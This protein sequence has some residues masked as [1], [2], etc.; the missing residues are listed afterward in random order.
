MNELSSELHAI[1][2]RIEEH[3]LAKE[4]EQSA[5][6][7]SPYDYLF[8]IL[9]LNECAGCVDKIQQGFEELK[10]LQNEIGASNK[11]HFPQ[12]RV[13]TRE[14]FTSVARVF[15]ITLQDLLGLSRA[16]IYSR[17]RQVACFIAHEVLGK[18]CG[19]IQVFIDRDHAT[20]LHACTRIKHLI[21]ADGA[22]KARVNEVLNMLGMAQIN[23]E[24]PHLKL[25]K[26]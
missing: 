6:A 4:G 18:S 23:P 26:G 21:E 1:S 11:L 24:K 25:V 20:I 2:S 15:K 3:L 19:Q 12:N 8:M 14:V 9:R 5:R 17:P 22:F 10:R 7:L 16:E 13:S